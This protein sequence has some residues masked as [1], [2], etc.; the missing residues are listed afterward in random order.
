MLAPDVPSEEHTEAGDCDD[1]KTAA[2]E[3]RAASFGA[4]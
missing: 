2:S 4:V 1:E 3:T